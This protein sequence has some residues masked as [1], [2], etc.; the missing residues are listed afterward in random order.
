MCIRLIEIVRGRDKRDRCKIWFCV[1]NIGWMHAPS[2]HPIAD[3][4]FS[5]SNFRDWVSC[6]SSMV[7]SSLKE[8]WITR[9]LESAFDE[10]NSVHDIFYSRG[11][12][13]KNYQKIFTLYHAKFCKPLPKEFF[14]IFNL[15][16]SIYYWLNRIYFL[17]LDDKILSFSLPPRFIL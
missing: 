11:I 1:G 7:E 13:L 17:N 16:S 10:R 15:K 5:S 14:S 8:N 4:S 12:I 6:T 2:S 3:F 9:R